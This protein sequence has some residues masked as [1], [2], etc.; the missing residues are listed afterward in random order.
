[1]IVAAQTG[2][3]Q[4]NIVELTLSQLDFNRN[5]VMVPK[6]KNG[7]PVAIPMTN[8]VRV[9]LLKVLH[10]RKIA[11]VYVFCD[12]FGKPH[13]GKKV[14]IA[15]KRAC[16]SAGIN[17]LRFHDLRHDF[18]TLMVNN[19]ASLYQVQHALGQKDQR[20][21]QRYAHLMP[22]TLKEAIKKIDSKGTA[23]I[24]LQ[25]SEMEK[26]NIAVSC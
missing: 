21:T 11:S 8:I 17:N 22:E 6:T 25:S 20:M 19:G 9:T 1:M 3:R 18:A 16:E 2:L 13:S 5:L 24:L 23:T 4:G 15:F 26:E 7:D 12:E 14:S 10:E